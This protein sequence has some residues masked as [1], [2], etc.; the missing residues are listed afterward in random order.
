MII[1]K[2]LSGLFSFAL[3]FTVSIPTS[4]FE[5]TTVSNSL[6]AKESIATEIQSKMYADDESSYSFLFGTNDVTFDFDKAMPF[7]VLNYSKSIRAETA[8]DMLEYAGYYIVPVLDKNNNFIAFAE[9]KQITDS[10]GVSD[11]LNQYLAQGYEKE[12]NDLLDKCTNHLGEWEII[13]ASTGGYTEEFYEF[14]KSDNT[15]YEQ[16]MSYKQAYLTEDN[17]GYNILFVSENE[18]K[19]FSFYKY[20]NSNSTF[21]VQNNNIFINGDDLLKEARKQ[22]ESYVKADENI[23]GTSGNTVDLNSDV[24]SENETSSNLQI[25]E[26]E[27]IEEDVPNPKTGSNSMSKI[28]IITVVSA[29]GIIKLN[30]RIEK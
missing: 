6:Y 30:K 25:T 2:L 11:I 13:G 14:I 29:L 24:D 22:Y 26:A 21:S 7:Y 23:S 19:Y 12:Y 10:E 15:I 9:F 20:L 16:I 4:A 17:S 8:S 1:K 3:I 18:E 28:L 27:S 5:T